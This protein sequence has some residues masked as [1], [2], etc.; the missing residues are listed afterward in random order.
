MKG[1]WCHR[2]VCVEVKQDRE[3]GMSVRWSG[4]NLNGF[5]PKG[6]L[7]CVLHIRV[8]WSFSRAYI[9]V[10][11]CWTAISFFLGSFICFVREI[12]RV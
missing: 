6:Y 4:K 1:M 12:F 8:F 2:E 5:I 10:Y 9:Y 3:G 7:G 11:G